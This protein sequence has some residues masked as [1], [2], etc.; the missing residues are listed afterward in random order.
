MEDTSRSRRKKSASERRAQALRAE[1]R[2][3]LRLLRGLA[4]LEEHRGSTVSNIGRAL[5]FLFQVSMQPSA[6]AADMELESIPIQP[7]EASV[8]WNTS[9]QV[10]TPGTQWLKQGCTAYPVGQ[11]TDH[12]GQG[13]DDRGLAAARS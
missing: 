6:S 1:T 8:K 13:R 7:S 4:D 11:E 3:A 10:F 5:Q 2:S 9:A 12:D